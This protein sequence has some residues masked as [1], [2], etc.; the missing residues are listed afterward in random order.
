MSCH[1]HRTRLRSPWLGG[2][3]PLALKLFCFCL[4]VEAIINPQFVAEILSTKPEIDI[5]ALTKV[6]EHEEEL[7]VDQVDREGECQRQWGRSTR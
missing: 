5:L 6:L 4:Q 2:S 1:Q 7:T 3:L